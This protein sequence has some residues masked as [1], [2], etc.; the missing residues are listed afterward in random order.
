MITNIQSPA[1]V[2]NT[3]K[4]DNGLFQE[5]RQKILSQ[6]LQISSEW[7]L[8]LKRLEASSDQDPLLRIDLGDLILPPNNLFSYAQPLTA[9]T[10]LAQ[11]LVLAVD[12]YLCNCQQSKSRTRAAQHVVSTVA[13]F[14]EY[15]WINDVIHLTSVS[16]DLTEKLRREITHGWSFALRL[17]ER[18]DAVPRNSILEAVK[19][20]RNS[21]TGIEVAVKELLKTNCTRPF[22]LANGPVRKYIAD[23]DDEKSNVVVL[24]GATIRPLMRCI[25]RLAFVDAEVGLQFVPYINEENY[26]KPGSRTENID[27]SVA[28]KLLCNS[29]QWAY[30][31]GPRL[32]KILKILAEEA[33]MRKARGLKTQGVNF[34]SI[35]V[36]LPEKVEIEKIIGCPLFGLDHPRHKEKISV[37]VK[38]LT[39]GLLTACFI[40]IALMNARRRDEVLHRKFGLRVGDKRIVNEELGLYLVDFYIEKTYKKRLPF[41]VNQMTKDVVELLENLVV[42]YENYFDSVLGTA[43]A[44]RKD[45][46]LFCHVRVSKK[47]GLGLDFSWYTF[48]YKEKEYDAYKFLRLVMGEELGRI[49]PHMFRRAYCLIMFY[50]Y[51]NGDLQALAFQ[52]GDT[53]LVSPIRYLTDP[54][55]RPELE[56]IPFK[57]GR[58]TWDRQEAYLAEAREVEEMYTEV[59][60]EKL[61]I[62]VCKIISGEEYYGGYSK[63][64]R[65]LHLKLVTA[66]K[67][68]GIFADEESQAIFEVIKKR[69]H[70][71]RPNPHGQCMA[72]TAMRVRVAKCY[73]ADDQKL[74]REHASPKKCS[75]CIFQLSSEAYVKNFTAIREKLSESLTV[76]ADDS[77][78]YERTKK[79]IEN[80]DR[81]IFLIRKRR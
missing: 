33:R 60:N 4:T 40:C 73:S 66:V 14:F 81:S 52:R 3:T 9:R 62:D 5:L 2:Q 80:L 18:I 46:P 74:H 54:A 12:N 37:T 53:D 59:G 27:L 21:G 41:Y 20:K 35:I 57:V 29:A 64:I 68:D 77:M 78:M 75:N 30:E 22:E 11:A 67:A 1:P 69:G 7:V 76:G 23:P 39:Q 17:F 13:H 31:V 49:Y 43:H 34:W 10:D 6:D 56:T 42:E 48:A 51:E 38:E 58:P 65:R 79:E 71:P 45:R 55:H 72:G 26:G 36:S 63:Y 32:L 28:V 50:R 47:Y 70:F 44:I 8:S 19:T 16:Q 24:G 61:F 15:M 25:N